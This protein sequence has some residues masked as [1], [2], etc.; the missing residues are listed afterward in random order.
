MN[1]EVRHSGAASLGGVGAAAGMPEA[2]ASP[3]AFST[4]ISERLTIIYF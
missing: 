1:S 3:K 2:Y 4:E